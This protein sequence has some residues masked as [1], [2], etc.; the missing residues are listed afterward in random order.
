MQGKRGGK[1]TRR[2]PQTPQSDY[3]V[4]TV[5]TVGEAGEQLALP[6][7]AERRLS[8][9]TLA[10]LHRDVQQGLRQ[11]VPSG[12]LWSSRDAGTRRGPGLGSA[13]AS[14]SEPRS[15]SRGRP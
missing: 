10:R 12:S 4:C 11:P 14:K 5:S 3:T 8:I 1:L 13:R 15:S 7:E 9:D 2:S 6:L